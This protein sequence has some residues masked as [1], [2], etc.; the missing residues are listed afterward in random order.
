MAIRTITTRGRGHWPAPPPV[1][2][3]GPSTPGA[4]RPR[5]FRLRVRRPDGGEALGCRPERSRTRPVDAM[6]ATARFF[7]RGKPSNPVMVRLRCGT[8]RGAGRRG[9]GG[10]SSRLPLS[11][12]R[13]GPGS[14]N[15]S[16]LCDVFSQRRREFGWLKPRWEGSAA[17]F[18]GFAWGP[19][20][21]PARQTGS[22]GIVVRVRLREMPSV[23]RADPWSVAGWCRRRGPVQD[24]FP[25]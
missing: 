25:S 5:I 1:M 13:F 19:G 24:A 21:P 14:P 16:L 15:L 20:A 10:W 23:P 7:G 11:V 8:S 2:I 22:V 18:F 12:R 17:E 4:G 9:P 3:A 6:A